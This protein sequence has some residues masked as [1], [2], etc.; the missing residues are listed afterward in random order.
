MGFA[1]LSSG[2]PAMLESPLV[3]SRSPT[4]AAVE[5]VPVVA[6][7]TKRFLNCSNDRNDGPPRAANI[8]G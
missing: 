5:I 1:A 4:K 8:S 3:T 7:R 2:G 6:F